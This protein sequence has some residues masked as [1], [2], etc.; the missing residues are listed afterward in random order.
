MAFGSR[1][2]T[3]RELAVS[4]RRAMSLLS[5]DPP[6]REIARRF[7]RE[8]DLLEAA[9]GADAAM[10]VTGY[11]EPIL[12]ASPV[13]VEGFE[14]PIY[15]RPPDLVE[16]PLDRFGS[17]FAGERLFGR[18]E[19]TRLV[20]YWTRAEIAAGKSGLQGCEIAWARDPVELFFVEVQGSA[21]LA[22][23]DGTERRI[24]YAASNG[25]PYVSIGKLLIDEGRIAREAMS[26]QALRAWL[27]SHPE[28]RRRVLDSNPSTVFFRTLEGPPVGSLGVPVTAGR[29]IATDHRLFPRG[30]LAFLVTERP[31]ERNAGAI[32]WERLSRFVLNQDTGGAIR[33]AGRVDLFWGRGA[34][35]ELCA[36]HMKQ[37]GRL[38][39]L[40]PKP[41][42]P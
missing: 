24:G 36:G 12:D 39:F 5:D 2:V 42:R 34:G 27:G 6:P 11:F 7:A 41:S 3:H 28:E 16:A 22:F 35:A 14:V 15:G 10:L 19:G 13:R 26:L 4:L 29:S 31:V 32:G 21:T 33:G 8:F 30:A 20:P 17:R 40:V 18:L 25:H 9:G 38:F 1:T 23:R 37:P